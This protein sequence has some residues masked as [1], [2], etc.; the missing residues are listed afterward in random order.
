MRTQL[1]RRRMTFTRKIKRFHSVSQ[2]LVRIVGG[3]TH[4]TDNA[5]LTRRTSGS[6][7]RKQMVRFGLGLAAAGAILASTLAPGV[8]AQTQATTVAAVQTV[9]QT[10]TTGDIQ[11]LTVA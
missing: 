7:S 5:R 6:V 3:M 11:P 8:L 1:A 9:S 10:V 4:P 2:G